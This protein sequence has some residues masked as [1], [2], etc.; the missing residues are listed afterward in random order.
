MNETP[1]RKFFQSP[2]GWWLINALIFQVGWFVCV[3]GGSL[4]ASLFTLVALIFHF[5]IF[6]EGSKDKVTLAVALVMGWLHDNLL[7]FAGVFIFAD[8][9]GFSPVWLWCLWLLMGTSVN[10]SLKWIYDRPW[11]S[12]LVGAVFGPLAYAGGVALSDVDWGVPMA[13]AFVIMAPLW[14]LV[15]PLLRFLAHRIDSLCR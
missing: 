12:A 14:L 1:A 2:R 7:A 4:W 15:L 9:A 5:V 8:G 10:H 11:I 6:P 3:V 13:Q